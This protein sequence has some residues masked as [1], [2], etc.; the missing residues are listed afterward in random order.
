MKVAGHS[1]IVISGMTIAG[2]SGKASRNGHSRSGTEQNIWGEK[3]KR[4]EWEW[5]SEMVAMTAVAANDDCSDH[6]R[7]CGLMT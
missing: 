5:E 3:E 2:H 7:N 4:M 6:D 1:G